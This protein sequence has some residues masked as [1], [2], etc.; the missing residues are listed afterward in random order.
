MNITSYTVEKLHDPTGILVG[1]R[2][3][4]LLD[5]VVDEDD[6]LYREQGI[7]VKVT[8]AVTEEE[9]KIAQYYILESGTN[10][11]LDFALEEEELEQILQFCIE[12]KEEAE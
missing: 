8:L 5:V 6:E 4:F 11:Y 10:Q 3:E 2:Y 7:Q 9:T 12:R 1:D